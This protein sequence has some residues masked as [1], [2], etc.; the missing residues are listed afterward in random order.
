VLPKTQL[1]VKRQE[2]KFLGINFFGRE[3]YWQRINQLA[4]RRVNVKKNLVIS[5]FNGI[6]NKMPF[7][8]S[9]F[10]GVI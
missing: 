7:I 9:R 6:S 1:G 5:V 10:G 2:K 4:Q 3:K 8:E